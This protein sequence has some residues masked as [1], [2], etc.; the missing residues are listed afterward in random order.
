MIP[1]IRAATLAVALV[2]TLA[3]LAAVGRFLIGDWA[4]AKR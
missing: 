2:M 3:G 1:R 4:T